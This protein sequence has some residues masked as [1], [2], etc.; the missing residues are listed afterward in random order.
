MYSIEQF[1][2]I[3]QLERMVLTQHSRKRFV[4]RGIQLQDIVKTIETGEII[5]YYPKDFPF[6]SCLITGKSGNKA[7][8]IVAAIDDDMIHLITAYIPDPA[9][10]ETDWKTRKEAQ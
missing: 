1:R 3:N 6:P 10:W 9:K 8:H 7:V 2:K 4:E 5:E